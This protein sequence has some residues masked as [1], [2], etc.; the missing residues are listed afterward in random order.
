MNRETVDIKIFS[1]RLS[2]LLSETDETVYSL[3][4][5]L[6]LSASTISRY[7]NGKMIPKIPTVY[8]MAKIFHVNPNWLMGYNVE[9]EETEDHSFPSY[10]TN[11]SPMP[12]M[13]KI[14]LLGEIACGEPIL[15]E[16]NISDY[17]DV[18]GHIKADFSL[19]CKGDSMIDAGIKDGDIVYIRQQPT[20]ENGQIAA[21]LIDNNE[22]TLK[23]VYVNKDHIILQSANSA[24]P[25]MVYGGNIPVKILG[26]AVAFIHLI[27]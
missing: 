27:K 21:V 19:T 16:E 17:I 20:I 15:A 24:Y 14:P 25:P 26:K 9:K 6:S 22:A 4:E 5:K 18:P 11:L 2:S 10:V 1:Q 13:K 7:A 23:R 3:A 12:P 8:S